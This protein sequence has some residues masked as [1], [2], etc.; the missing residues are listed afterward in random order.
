[1]EPAVIVV[2]VILAINMLIL[3]GVTLFTAKRF[4]KKRNSFG[5][6]MVAQPF[7]SLVYAIAVV[8]TMTYPT[9]YKPIIDAIPAFGQIG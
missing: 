1:M 3:G 6:L 2:I 8:F 4:I 5:F 7:I 9:Q